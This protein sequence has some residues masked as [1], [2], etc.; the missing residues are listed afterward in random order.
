MMRER[1]ETTLS[2]FSLSLYTLSLCVYIY[3]CGMHLYER[4]NIRRKCEEK[5]NAWKETRE[6]LRE[7]FFT[8]THTHVHT[9]HTHT[10][11]TRTGTHTERR[12]Q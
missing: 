11:N 7:L 4:E 6:K 5:Q 3:V 1:E 8:H 12:A 10:Q 9:Q 2:L